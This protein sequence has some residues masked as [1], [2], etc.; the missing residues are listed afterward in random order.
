MKCSKF[1]PQNYNNSP[2]FTRNQVR[3]LFF[4]IF[5]QSIS[6]TNLKGEAGEVAEYL[7][8]PGGIFG[9]VFVFVAADVVKLF[10]GQF[11]EVVLAGHLLFLQKFAHSYSAL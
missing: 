3:I 10:R 8:A 9:V 6:P 7:L 11:V 5:W 1:C 2:A 4:I